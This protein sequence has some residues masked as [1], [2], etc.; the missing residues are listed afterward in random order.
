MGFSPLES[1]KVP[2]VVP[3]NTN[4]EAAVYVTA[5]LRNRRTR[6]EFTVLCV[7]IAALVAITFFRLKSH[8]RFVDTDDAYITGHPHIVSSRIEGVVEEVCVDDN[9]HVKRGQTLV[10]L[11][12]HDYK[13][14]VD[15]ASARVLSAQRKVKVTA[16]TIRLDELKANAQKLRADGLVNEAKAEI[17]QS[18]DAV[19]AA[20]HDLA[21][22]KDAVAEQNAQLVRAKLDHDRYQILVAKGVVSEQQRDNAVRD[23][24]LYQNSKK[25]AEKR[26]LESQQKLNKIRD[27]VDSARARLTQSFGQEEQ[28]ESDKV[29]IDVARRDYDVALADEKQ[30]HADL[31]EAKLQLHYCNIYAPT[32]GR[33][34]KRTVEVGHRI[35]PG[36]QLITVV[37]DYF[38]VVANYKETQVKHMRPGQKVRISVDSIPGHVFSAVVDSFSPGA[39]STFSLIPPDNATGNFTK[40]VQR[41]PV[42][43]RLEPESI[44]GYEDRLIVGMSVVSVVD[45]QS[46]LQTNLLDVLRRLDEPSQ[47]KMPYFW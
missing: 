14:A 27:S 43:I 31:N 29:Q 16:E 21:A 12:P 30:A 24:D 19:L 8:S 38:W 35:N 2:K 25:A 3:I 36:E 18:Q 17:A 20:Q 4:N 33:I 41:I 34:G 5:A 15:L 7:L 9:D 42:K 13:I 46:K 45:T 23:Y 11:D 39:G 32:A 10:K 28:A 22:S 44:K 26:V 6:M 1:I 40:I 47:K 37:E